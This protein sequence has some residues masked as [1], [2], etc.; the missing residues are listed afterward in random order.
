[1]FNRILVTVD[2]SDLSERAL[3]PAFHIAQKF[4]A[5][6]IL[7]RVVTPEPVA[8]A[9]RLAGEYGNL[10]SLRDRQDQQD[11]LDAEQYLRGLQAEWH[12][13]HVPIRTQTGSGAA[14]QVILDVA[15]A[16]DADL[17]VMSTHGRAGF[18]RL[19]YG[20]VAEA[21]LRGTRLPV[22]LIPIK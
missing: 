16:V 20:S 10:N 5:Q 12:N 2:G 6:V 7:L 3:E 9:G 15:E 18:S 8:L 19:L 4:G 21:V 22:L 11:L 17:I 13:T 1:M 14:P